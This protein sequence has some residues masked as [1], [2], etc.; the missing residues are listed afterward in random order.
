MVKIANYYELK[1][2]LQAS[3]ALP[4]LIGIDGRACSGKSTLAD[5]LVADL[6]ASEFNLDDLVIPF[7]DQPKD[8][9]P[10]FPFPYFRYH[11]FLEG[12]RALAKGKSYSFFPYDWN[13]DTISLNEHIVEPK[14]FI[15]IHGVSTL[16]S[17][18]ISCFHKKIFVVSDE[19]TELEAAV[20]RDGRKFEKFWLNLWIPSEA[21]YMETKPWTRA[22]V[23]YAA[24]GIK[25]PKDVFNHL[26]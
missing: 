1:Q 25:S 22:D 2:E 18:T 5:R 17:D 8:L 12:I 4:C 24:R 21:K 10:D 16:N 7:R 23:L 13:N 11:L 20:T 14:R 9:K 19:R 3:K 15:V 6:A 26:K